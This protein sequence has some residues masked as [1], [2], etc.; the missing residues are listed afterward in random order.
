M[1]AADGKILD[2]LDLRTAD[3]R[4]QIRRLKIIAK[5]RIN[6]LMIVSQRQ[7]PVLSVETV[8]AKVIR[9]RRAGAVSPPIS[10]GT[11]DLAQKRVIC[12]N[13]SSLTHRDMMGRIK[14]RRAD[15]PYR[16]RIFFLAV[17]RIFRTQSVAVVLDQ[18]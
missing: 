8:L 7:F 13:R 4:L 1:S 6:I 2:P 9:P 12:I 16:T 3:G 10:E 11:H 5:L 14:A 18:P 15:I 17:D